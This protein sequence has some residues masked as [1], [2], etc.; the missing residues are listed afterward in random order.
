MSKQTGF[1]LPATK[2]DGNWTFDKARFQQL[3]SRLKDGAYEFVVE[4][5]RKSRSLRINRAYWACIVNPISEHTGYEPDE[6]HELLKRFC[7]PKTVEMVDKETGEVE[8]VTIGGSTASM[9]TED[10]NLYFARCQQFAAERLDCICPDPDPEY[11][12]HRYEKTQKD[13]AA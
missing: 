4:A 8:E 9:T 12:L 10:F 7:N 1:T 3:A 11:Q 2:A 6:V 13:A 5:V